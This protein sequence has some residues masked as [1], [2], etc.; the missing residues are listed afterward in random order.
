[1]PAQV[2]DKWPVQVD[3]KGVV[4]DEAVISWRFWNGPKIN[5][6]PLDF[7]DPGV[8]TNHD[9]MTKRGEDAGQDWTETKDAQGFYTLRLTE[10]QTTALSRGDFVYTMKISIDGELKTFF[11]GELKLRHSWTVEP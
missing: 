2:I 3:Y 5:N 1:M 9:L 10:A 4:G 8:T 7:T 6:N 11:N